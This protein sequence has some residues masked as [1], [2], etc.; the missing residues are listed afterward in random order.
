MSSFVEGV[1]CSHL[2]H[3]H[4]EANRNHQKMLSKIVF[5]AKAIVLAILFLIAKLA[6]NFGVFDNFWESLLNRFASIRYAKM[7]KRHYWDTL[8]G[9][10]MYYSTVY[11]LYLDMQKQA[12][13][14]QQAPN[15]MI[16]T[17]EGFSC[18]LLHHH[19]HDR[20]LVVVFGSCTCP[21]FV[22]SLLKLVEVEKEFGC[23]ADFVLIYIEEAHAEDGWKFKV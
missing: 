23:M 1:L 7:K 9:Y 6:V 12:R 16:F 22:A 4:P 21:P 18:K 11:T 15:S 14:G 13:M 20:P 2:E 5:F 19:N 8:F 3:W 10:Q 17:M